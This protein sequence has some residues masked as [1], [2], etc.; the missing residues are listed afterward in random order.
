MP[1]CSLF[2]NV[3]VHERMLDFMG[4]RVHLRSHARVYVRARCR[5][6]GV[7]SEDVTLWSFITDVTLSP[8]CS[9]TQRQCFIKE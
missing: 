4:A 9:A 1:P 2:T 6:L 8:L 7:R 5:A 3:Y